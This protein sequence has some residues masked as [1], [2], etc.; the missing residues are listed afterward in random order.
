MNE[1]EFYKLLGPEFIL[2]WGGRR[3]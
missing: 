2:R 1:R 3:R